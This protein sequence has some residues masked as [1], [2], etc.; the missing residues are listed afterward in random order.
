M[1]VA[2]HTEDDDATRLWTRRIKRI[3]T[4]EVALF[5]LGRLVKQ[6]LPGVLGLGLSHKVNASCP[7][8]VCRRVYALEIG[9]QRANTTEMA[10]CFRWG[11]VQLIL[12]K[13]I[14]TTDDDVA[15][16]IQELMEFQWDNPIGL[17]I[18]SDLITPY[19]ILPE[20]AARS[21]LRLANSGTIVNIELIG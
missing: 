15:E 9:V 20:E 3:A 17:L 21:K 4:T 12:A 6:T 7:C 1:K 16:R 18:F 13:S 10:A 2:I 8:K 19:S 11:I 14:V 5:L